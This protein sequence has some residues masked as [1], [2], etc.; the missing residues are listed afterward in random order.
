[1]DPHESTLDRSYEVHEWIMTYGE[2][3]Q[4]R[5]EEWEVW[6]WLSFRG[7]WLSLRNLLGER[8]LRVTPPDDYPFRVRR[9]RRTN[10]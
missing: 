7:S 5:E 8:D 6:E 10:S 1:M 3:R 9:W 4:L 2:L